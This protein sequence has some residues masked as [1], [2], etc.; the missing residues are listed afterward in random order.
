MRIF[1]AFLALLAAA[2]V[3]A[4]P[5]SP[6]AGRVYELSEVEVLPRP[7]NAA[8]FRAALQAAYPLPMR[9]GTVHV[10]FVRRVR[11]V[12]CRWRSW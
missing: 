2:P 12:P 3:V 8:E 5:V 11:E 1:P 9:D 6:D 7:Q 4:Q 10:S